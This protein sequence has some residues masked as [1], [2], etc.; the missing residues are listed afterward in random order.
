MALSLI[1]L[2][3]CVLMLITGLDYAKQISTMARIKQHLNV[4]LHAGSL[5][6][7]E[8]RLS[9]GKLRL[10]VTTPGFRVQD[11]FYKYLRENMILDNSNRAGPGS[12]LSVG[13]KVEVHSL[14]YADPETGLLSILH[15]SGSNCTVSAGK[16]K[17]DMVLHAGSGDETFRPLDE[18]LVGPSL[19]SL[20]E[21]EHQGLG[22]L[23]EEPIVIAG[24]QEVRFHWN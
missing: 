5:S 11:Q 6:V 14:L 9:Q 24:V 1:G 3:F 22:W 4:A 13:S 10:D 19:I 21:V 20:V 23:G 17:C 15:G 2:G 12:Y 18:L 8:V 16:L 7:D